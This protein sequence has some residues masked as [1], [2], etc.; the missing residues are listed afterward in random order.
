MLRLPRRRLRAAPRHP[1]ISKATRLGWLASLNDECYESDESGLAR[2]TS[3]TNIPGHLKDGH[4]E[5]QLHLTLGEQCFEPGQL[6]QQLQV[7]WEFQEHAF[8]DPGWAKRQHN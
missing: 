7:E 5:F 4:A 8:D 3:L 1:K 6:R 2:L